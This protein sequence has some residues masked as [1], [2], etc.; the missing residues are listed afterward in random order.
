MEQSLSWEANWFCTLSRNYPHLWNQKVHYRTHKCPP[1]VPILSQLHP[2]PTSYFTYIKK[3]IQIRSNIT[4]G[5]ITQTV[6]YTQKL[7]NMCN[8]PTNALVCNKTLIQMSHTKT[9]KITPT[10]FEHQLIIIRELIWSWLKSLV[11]IWV[12]MYGELGYAAAYVRS[13]YML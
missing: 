7:Y 5:W 4:L 1:P 6:S 3:L 8:R 12:F 13:F 2:V 10:C 11:K 9:I